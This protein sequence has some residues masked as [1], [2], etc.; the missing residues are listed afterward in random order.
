MWKAIDRILTVMLV[1]VML[2][3]WLGSAR[4][5]SI[6]NENIREQAEE[7]R[8][9]KA[10]VTELQLVYVRRDHPPVASGGVIR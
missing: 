9:L 8:H 1:G 4:A 5:L 2:A 3:L 6:Q 7:I 10:S